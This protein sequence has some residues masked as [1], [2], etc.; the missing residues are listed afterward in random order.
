MPAF[1]RASALGK[2]VISMVSYEGLFQ[3]SLVIIGIIGV[4]LS[5]IALILKIRHRK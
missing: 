2:E 1:L 5:L 4:L 3:Y